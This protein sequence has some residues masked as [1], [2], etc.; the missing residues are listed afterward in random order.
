[1]ASRYLLIV[2][3]IIFAGAV[4]TNGFMFVFRTSYGNV[5]HL[6]LSGSIALSLIAMLIPI[7]KN[8]AIYVYGCSLIAIASLWLVIVLRMD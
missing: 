8:M 3:S 7:K 6:S 1:M 2:A 5:F 4:F